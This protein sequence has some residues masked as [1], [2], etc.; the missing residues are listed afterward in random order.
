MRT[1]GRLATPHCAGLVAI[2]ARPIPEEF[3]SID[4]GVSSGTLRRKGFSGLVQL[5]GLYFLVAYSPTVLLSAT[6]TSLSG[7]RYVLQQASAA[8]AIASFHTFPSIVF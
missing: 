3:I 1:L 8:K 7:V 4:T 6:R 5:I 2:T